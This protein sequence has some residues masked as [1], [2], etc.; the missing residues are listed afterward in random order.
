M[1]DDAKELLDNMMYAPIDPEDRSLLN[2]YN[3]LTTNDIDDL[4]DETVFG[5]FFIEFNFLIDKEKKN[6]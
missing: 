2:L 4:K 1:P 5:K 3:I 6:V